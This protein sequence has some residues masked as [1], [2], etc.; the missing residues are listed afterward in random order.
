L[1]GGWRGGH[2]E[3]AYHFVFFLKSIEHLDIGSIADS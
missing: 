3:A 2:H 1:R